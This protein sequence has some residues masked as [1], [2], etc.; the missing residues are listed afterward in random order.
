M[1]GALPDLLI[2]YL[3]LEQFDEATALLAELVDD[4]RKARSRRACSS[5]P[6]LSAFET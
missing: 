2:T 1:R 3:H 4:L 6:G 5:P